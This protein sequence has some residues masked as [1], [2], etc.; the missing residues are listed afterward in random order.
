VGLTDSAADAGLGDRDRAALLGRALSLWRGSPL[1]GLTGAWVERVRT[2]WHARRLDATVRWAEAE[3][4]LGRATD[5]VVALADLVAE[6]RFVEP[7]P[8]A[9][10]G[11][12]HASG[13]SAEALAYYATTRRRL[14]EELGTEPGGHLR[15]A[16]RAVLRGQPMPL[17]A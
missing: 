5:V 12:L 10:I 2:G 6:H 8:A 3:L 1:A 16:H 4:R 14:V 13:R 17:S 11:A 9:F 7:L 15:A